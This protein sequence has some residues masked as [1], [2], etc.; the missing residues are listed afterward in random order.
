MCL[1]DDLH[2]LSLHIWYHTP[3]SLS[4]DDSRVAHAMIS[5]W[6]TSWN[7]VHGVKY[8]HRDLKQAIILEVMDPVTGVKK[9]VVADFGA[10]HPLSIEQDGGT[11]IRPQNATTFMF[12]GTAAE[13]LCP[14]F[15]RLTLTAI[16]RPEKSVPPMKIDQLEKVWAMPLAHFFHFIFQVGPPNLKSEKWKIGELAI[17]HSA[18]GC[19]TVYGDYF[20]KPDQILDRY[21]LL[22]FICINLIIF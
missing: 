13:F 1:P 12:Q 8:C 7:E 6:K 4:F 2:Y 3:G 17:A 19:Y 16:N 21:V 9:W 18:V 15:F 10:A 14:V 5:A 20:L 22:S 11:E